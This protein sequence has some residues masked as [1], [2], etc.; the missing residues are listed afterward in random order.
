MLVTVKAAFLPLAAP[1]S[2]GS[3]VLADP[4]GSLA[5]GPVAVLLPPRRPRR[6]ASAAVKSLIYMTPLVKINL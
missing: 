2:A 1:A 6:A 5:P 3:V 4:P